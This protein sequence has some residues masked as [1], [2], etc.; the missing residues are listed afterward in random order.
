MFLDS[1]EVTRNS[2]D[3]EYARCIDCQHCFDRKFVTQFS[4][5]QRTIMSD[6]ERQKKR[7]SSPRLTIDNKAKDYLQIENL[8]VELSRARE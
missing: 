8:D 1:S 5:Q 2:F 7:Q 6:R 3:P 4:C